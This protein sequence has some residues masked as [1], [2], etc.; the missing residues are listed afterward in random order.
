[1]YLTIIYFL[2]ALM[3]IALSIQILLSGVRPTKTLAWMLVI[4]LIPVFGILLYVVFGINRRQY[5]F[6]RLKKTPVYRRYLATVK[7]F[8]E[9][10]EEEAKLNMPALQPHL[11]LSKLIIRSTNFLPSGGNQVQ[12]LKDGQV[13]FESIFEALE[14]AQH[15]IHFQ[16]Y[17]FEEGELAER[18][19]Q[20]FLRKEQEGVEVR[21]IYDGIGSSSLSRSY[22]NRLKEGGVDIFG[23]LPLRFGYLTTT[24]NY[25]NH[26]KIIVVDGRVGF[27][28]GINVSDKYIKG[29]PELGTWHDVH[30]RIE[31][32]AVN[33]L[34]TVF[35]VDWLFAAKEDKLM[36]AAYFPAAQWPK[37]E[38]QIVQIV[39]SGPD[40]NFASVRQQYFTLIN[41]AR[42]YVYITNS[43]VIPGEAILEALQTAALSGVDVRILVPANSDVALVKWSIRSYFQQLLESG[44]KIYLFPEG[45]LHNKTIVVDDSVASIGTANLDIRSFEQNFEVNAQ[46]YDAAIARELKDYFLDDCAKSIRL[47]LKT[48]RARPL[49]HKILEGIGK[50]L[51][52]IL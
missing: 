27:T 36:Q 13:T 51:S 16:Y 1:M 37:R 52:P 38:G 43:Y 15:F 9:S 10:I 42:E 21:V 20:L 3:C 22:I 39:A 50:V 18:L 40:S 28:G 33:S 23:F 29:D 44:V 31:G 35:A 25:R 5:K 46:I 7:A 26:R 2:Y 47:D 17:I 30:L 19:L 41:E 8:Y 12:V 45:F 49:S 48:H 6:F 4:I 32:P 24:L 11:K 34:N 14:K